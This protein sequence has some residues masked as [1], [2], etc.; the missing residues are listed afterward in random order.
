[1]KPFRRKRRPGNRA[2]TVDQ[3]ARIECRRIDDSQRQGR[4]IE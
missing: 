3:S 2:M 4:L 1:M